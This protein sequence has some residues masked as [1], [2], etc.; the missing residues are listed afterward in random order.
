MSI[1]LRV[2]NHRWSVVSNIRRGVLA[3]GLGVAV[4]L[5]APAL[6]FAQGTSAAPSA[7]ASVAAST[8]ASTAA[9]GATRASA[10]GSVT[11]G[12]ASAA[13]AASVGAPAAASAAP[14]PAASAGKP[15]G[16]IVPTETLQQPNF[17]VYLLVALAA[18]FAIY[19]ILNMLRLLFA[20]PPAVVAAMP[21]AETGRAFLSFVMPFL[22]II[23]VLGVVICWGELFLW[24]AS[25]SEWYTLG[26][27]L[28][29]VCLVMAIATLMAMRTSRG[30]DSAVH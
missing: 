21:P 16:A 28:F 11:S 13:P 17:L 1:D 22:A 29:V 19:A 23:V 25:F 20:P 14:A 8:A 15:V 5:A 7:S 10:A 4:L 24:A 9:S 26:I 3:A 2:A 6:T 30:G 18:L 27:D 12:S